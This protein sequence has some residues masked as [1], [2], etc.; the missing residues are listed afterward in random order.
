MKIEP[1]ILFCVVVTMMT[2]MLH[3]SCSHHLPC[4]FAIPHT[5]EVELISSS[6]GLGFA[7]AYRFHH[8]NEAKSDGTPVIKLYLIKS[9]LYAHAYSYTSTINSKIWD[10]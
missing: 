1:K 2:L 4:D 3:L 7:L 9:C 6:F 8:L 5:K 10:T